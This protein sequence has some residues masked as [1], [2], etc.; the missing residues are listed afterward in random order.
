MKKVFLFIVTVL[1]SFN[2]FAQLEVR[3]GSFH[4]VEGFVNLNM[5][6]QTDDNDGPYAVLKIRTENIDGKQRRQ[7]SFKG[8]DL[9]VEN[10][11]WYDAQE[12]IETL[13]N[14][15]GEKFRLP[16]EAEWEYAARGGE[17]T[18]N[19]I[20]SGSNDIAKVAPYS[21][22][23]HPVGT[24]LANELGIYDMTGNVWEWC[25][26]WFQN[27]Y[28]GPTY[29][30]YTSDE[31]LSDPIGPASGSTRVIRGCCF[32]SNIRY[33]QVTCRSHDEP[34]IRSNNCGFRLVLGT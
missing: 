17:K 33:R 25:Q 34:D 28:D 4:K 21:L 19:Y 20:Y 26:D 14:L 11:S 10:V 8:E 2:V 31:T 27:Y 18:K 1:L 16:T 7:L 5:D 23:T 22:K 6:K 15:T 30:E 9:P 24:Q 29:K 13:N 3:Q 32:D 12:F